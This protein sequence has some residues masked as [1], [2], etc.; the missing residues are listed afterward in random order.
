[1][2]KF[3]VGVKSIIIYNRKALLVRRSDNGYWEFPGGT[4]EFGEDLHTTL[5]REIKEETGLEDI[6][7]GKL[8]YA[9]TFAYSET[10]YVG[11]M[12]LS[13]A[14]SD[15]VTIS[16]EHTDF[17]WADK[18]QFLNLLSEFMLNEITKNNVLDSLE[19]D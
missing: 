17:I 9:I 7:I 4:M 16:H 12:Y 2:G 14:N 8:L 6:D 15:K 10:Q 3:Q 13:H 1:M 5:R 18:K 11:L 19:I